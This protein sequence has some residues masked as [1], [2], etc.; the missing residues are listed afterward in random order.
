MR[1]IDL[2]CD[3]LTECEKRSLTLFNDQTQL[4]FNRLGK[5]GW[6]QAA[7]VFMPDTLRGKEAVEYF[8]RVYAYWLEQRELFWG[9]FSEAGTLSED[10]ISNPCCPTAFLTVEG[11]SVL[12]GDLS[13]I[14]LLAQ[15]GVR[16][17]TLTWN[18]ANELGGGQAEDIGLTP[19]GRQAV[20]LLEQH[21]I[22]ADVSHMG[23]RGFWEV[24]KLA[25]RPFVASHSN[26][27]AVCAHPRNLTDDQFKAIVAAEGLAGI[28]FCSHFISENG[29]DTSPKMLL[30]HIY[31]FAELGGEDYIALGSDYDGA[32]LPQWMDRSEKLDCA[33]SLMIKSG[34]ESALAEK[35]CYK[36]ARAFFARYE[37]S[38]VG[39]NHR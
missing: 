30:K 37:A 7:A 3:T 34:L 18:G 25:K 21:S 8:E 22:I 6:C 24:V 19:F 33:I 5:D 4:A 13:R 32:D 27:R 16:M 39:R 9:N 36:N 2:H 29:R 35:I 11:G 12:A 38:A 23:D 28:N 1:I 26:A 20:S 10:C 15:R 17:L 31:H 14:A